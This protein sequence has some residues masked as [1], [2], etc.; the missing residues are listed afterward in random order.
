MVAWKLRVQLIRPVTIIE[1]K[2]ENGSC[3]TTGAGK[4][5]IDHSILSPALRRRLEKLVTILLAGG[6]AE[7]RFAGRRNNIGDASDREEAAA[8]VVDLSSD[9][10]CAARACYR[11][12]AHRAEK[13]VQDHWNLIEALAAE[14]LAH[15]SMKPREVRA[16]LE[17]L[18]AVG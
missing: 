7:H 17:S 2:W 11:D 12:L 15:K 16:F 5:A 18:C 4:S 9:Y 6:A 1:N 13:I 3:V 10:D 8:L 14:L